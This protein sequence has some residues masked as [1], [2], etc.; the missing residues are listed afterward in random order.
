MNIIDNNTLLINGKIFKKFLSS[1]QINIIVS[2]LSKRIN[3]DFKDRKPIFLLVL[4]GSIFFGADLLRKINFECSVTTISAKSYGN[5]MTS[6]GKVELGKLSIDLK[7]KDIVIV[8]DII[9]SGFTMK[10]IID[11]ISKIKPSSIKIVSLL[12]K[13]SRRKV[14][15]NI[16]YV[17]MEIP[18]KFVVGYGLDYAEKGRNLPDIYALNEEN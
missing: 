11:E 7:D 5:E 9:D 2:K 17:G 16:D 10:K 13:P 18:D 3:S 12:S 1:K 6:S 14:N 4:N 15:L 8:E